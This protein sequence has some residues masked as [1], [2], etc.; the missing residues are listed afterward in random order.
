LP[1]SY[2]LRKVQKDD[3]TEGGCHQRRES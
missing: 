1:I 2:C 3:L